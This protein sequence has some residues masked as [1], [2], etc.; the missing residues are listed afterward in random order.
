MADRGEFTKR[1]LLNGKINLVKAE[2]I[3][4]LIKS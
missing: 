1:A 3:N 2:S 4:D